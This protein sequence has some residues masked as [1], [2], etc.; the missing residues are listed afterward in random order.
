MTLGE[1]LRH[2]RLR[3]KKTLHE[4]GRILKVSMNSVYR[5]EHDIAVPRRSMLKKMADHFE[6]PLDWLLS[7]IAAPS[8]ARDL[9]DTLLAI[10][11]EL[12]DVL[13]HKTIKI[14]ETI[15]IEAKEKDAKNGNG[16]DLAL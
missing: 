13:K 4:Q 11:R 1:K 5:W 15:H 6:T 10:F 3:T 16:H 2:L 8:L 12:P 9:E 14:I 7:D